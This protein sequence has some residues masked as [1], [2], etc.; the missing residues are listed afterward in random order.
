MAHF[1]LNR[2]VS[3]PGNFTLEVGVGHQEVVDAVTKDNG[4]FYKI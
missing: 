4:H 2:S 3:Q 1:L